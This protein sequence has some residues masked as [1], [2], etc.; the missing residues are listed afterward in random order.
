MQSRLTPSI[1]KALVA[2]SRRTS[3]ELP[4]GL[5]S[6]T[7]NQICVAGWAE[8]ADGDLPQA[9]SR[10]AITLAGRRAILSTPS[11]GAG[12]GARWR[13]SAGSPSRASPPSTTR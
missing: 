4:S 12:P 3:G 2:A 5:T 10:H 9:G 7:L 11:G 8:P 6:R 13:R 1:R